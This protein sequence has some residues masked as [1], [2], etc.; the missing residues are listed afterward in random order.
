VNGLRVIAESAAARASSQKELLDRQKEEALRQPN[1]YL[2][3][4]VQQL[5]LALQVTKEYARAAAADLFDAEIKT[6]DARS[7]Q[8]L[9][10]VVDP[11]VPLWKTE[12]RSHKLLRQAT[13]SLLVAVFLAVILVGALDPTVLDDQDLRRVGLLP[14]GRVPVSGGSSSRA[15]V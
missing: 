14:L 15:E 11:G 7:I 10:Q 6:R 2:D 9:V 13:L 12:S 4:R 3:L 1:R 5:A 8:R